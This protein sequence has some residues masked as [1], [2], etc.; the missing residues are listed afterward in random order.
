MGDSDFYGNVGHIE[1]YQLQGASLANKLI[2]EF[3]KTLEGLEGDE[4]IKA[5]EHAN[6]VICDEFEKLSTDVLGKVLKVSTNRM[7]NAYQR[8]VN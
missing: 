1:R 8:N 3:D 6:Q 2:K 7:K 4:L 5:A